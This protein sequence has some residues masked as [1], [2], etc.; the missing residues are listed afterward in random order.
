MTLTCRDVDANNETVALTNQMDLR[1]KTAPRPP[2]RMVRRFLELRLLASAEFAGA[3]RLFFSP[4]RQPD[5]P[6]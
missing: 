5:W 3:A 6:G 2:E 1:P 4:R